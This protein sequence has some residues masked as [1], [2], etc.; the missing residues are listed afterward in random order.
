MSNEAIIERM[1]SSIGV[2][3]VKGDSFRVSFT[4]DDARTA[5][6]VTERLAS[7]FIEENLRD[8]EVLAEGTNQFLSAQIEDVRRRIVEKEL[9]LRRLRATTSGELSQGDVLPYEVLKESYKA[10]LQKELDARVGANLE[11]RQIGQ[12]FKI[13]DPAR[14][15]E[16]P[17]GPSK[18]AVNIGG[19]L[20]GLALGL[21]MMGAWGRRKKPSAPPQPSAFPQV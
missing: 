9:E 4:S 6:R 7:L 21:V 10:L 18:T 8:R 14:L 1:R 19:T 15:P 11:R 16:A 5:M 13:L 12:Q 2:E 3:I 20:A 17:I